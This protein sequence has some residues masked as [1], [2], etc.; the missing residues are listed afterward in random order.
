MFIA[1][2]CWYIVTINVM[3]AIKASHRLQTQ[4]IFCS[5]YN[6]YNYHVWYSVFMNA[7]IFVITYLILSWMKHTISSHVIECFYLIM[8]R[9]QWVCVIKYYLLHWWKKT[10]YLCWSGGFQNVSYPIA[11]DH[12]I[13]R[14]FLTLKHVNSRVWNTS[15]FVIIY[16]E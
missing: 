4:S 10:N 6:R 11:Y 3:A 14:I 16:M 2:I 15:G 13:R 5:I 7:T 8:E 9:P 12:T 1:Y